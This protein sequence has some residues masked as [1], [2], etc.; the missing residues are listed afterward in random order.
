MVLCLILPFSSRYPWT[1]DRY[2]LDDENAII[3]IENNDKNKVLKQLIKN[4]NYKKERLSK[5]EQ[6]LYQRLIGR[7][8]R[9]FTKPSSLISF[10]VSLTFFSL[11]VCFFIFTSKAVISSFFLVKISHPI[12]AATMF[13]NINNIGPKILWISLI[14]LAINIISINAKIAPEAP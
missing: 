4:F 10:C 6:Q 11:T 8:N 12:I 3:V 1:K 14:G 9:Q 5:E 13:I 2:I 7:I